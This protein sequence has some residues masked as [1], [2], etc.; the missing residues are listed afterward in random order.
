MKWLIL[1]NARTHTAKAYS[2]L[3]FGKSIGTRCPTGT[4][5]YADQQGVKQVIDCYFKIGSNKGLSK[6]LIEISKDLNVK[7]PTKLKLEQLR[8]ILSNH[9]A[10]KIVSSIDYVRCLSIGPYF[11]HHVS[12]N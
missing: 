5:K 1:D 6:G 8:D 10:F 7:L 12:K 11:R 2:L 9:P 3:N 4:I